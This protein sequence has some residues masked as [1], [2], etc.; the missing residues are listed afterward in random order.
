MPETIA[1]FVRREFP[2]VKDTVDS[3]VEMRVVPKDKES[4]TMTDYEM[5]A[6]VNNDDDIGANILT[7]DRNVV[8]PQW[9]ILLNRLGKAMQS[10]PKGAAV[11]RIP[12]EI[13]NVEVVT[14]TDYNKVFDWSYDDL[15]V[16]K[17]IFFYVRAYRVEFD[18]PA[19]DM[20]EV[21]NAVRNG[22]GS[23]FAF[24]VL[25]EKNDPEYVYYFREAREKTRAFLNVMA[26]VVKLI[27]FLHEQGL[28]LNS[29]RGVYVDDD[30][31]VTM[32]R[33]EHAD[34]VPTMDVDTVCALALYDDLTRPEGATPYELLRRLHRASPLKDVEPTPMFNSAYD[35]LPTQETHENAPTPEWLLPVDET[36]RHEGGGSSVAAWTA[37]AAIAFLAA[38]LK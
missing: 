18:E 14:R 7:H 23:R 35:F 3:R 22:P 5:Q 36:E 12:T 1:D 30:G 29:M 4:S 19:I 28:Y 6:I 16:K 38:A 33:L 9:N 24:E 32:S 11:V 13:G 15:D 37:L 25:A 34:N 21:A 17:N 20:L 26:P 10:R 31:N 8:R 27:E 2:G